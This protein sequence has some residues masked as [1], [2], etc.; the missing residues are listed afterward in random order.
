MERSIRKDRLRAGWTEAKTT[1]LLKI[2]VNSG[3]IKSFATFRK[4]ISLIS[5][6]RSSHFS[7]SYIIRTSEQ[8]NNTRINR[9][10]IIGVQ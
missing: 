1:K 10:S 7:D 5:F 4:I 8:H 6:F 9:C 3:R 2:T